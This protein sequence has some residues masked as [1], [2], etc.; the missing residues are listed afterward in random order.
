LHQ[1]L[2]G[3][4]RRHSWLTSAHVEVL[5]LANEQFGY[6]AFG[7]GGES[8]VVLLNIGDEPFGF[9]LEDIGAVELLQ[10][11]AGDVDGVVNAHGWAVLRPVP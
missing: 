10:G 11:N 8:L 2:I 9:P 6:R 7:P 5:T 4:R 1:D 3:L